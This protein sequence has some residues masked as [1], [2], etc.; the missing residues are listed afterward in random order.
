MA[1]KKNT[2]RTAIPESPFILGG[3]SFISQLG[4][5]PPLS[6]SGQRLLVE[7]CLEHGI[8]W[9]DTT[10][11]PERVALGKALKQLGARDQ[12]V[13]IAW[14]FFTDFKDRDPVGGAEYYRPHH[15]EMM[16]EQLKTDYI[17]CLVVH[18]LGNP[19]EDARQMELAVEW[20]R[21]GYITSLGTWLPGS[22]VEEIFRDSPYTFMIKPY[23]IRTRE[24]TPVFDACRRQGWLNLACSP[25]IRG[26]ELDKM[27]EWARQ[28]EP[29]ASGDAL[30]TRL[31]DHLLRFSLFGPHVDRLI[32]AIRQ[33][34]W[35]TTNCASWR[36]G[37][38]S[39]EEKS[40]LLERA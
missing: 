19:D 31:A 12:A 20:L 23:N 1:D 24:S 3:H 30:K 10:Y 21:K 40:W 39:P 18:A 7:T 16:L 22:D 35:V 38:L 36:K 17:D 27:T 8:T 14:N 37:P 32:V 26:W 15:I 9:F 6:K 29:D 4:N 5:D 28:K 2:H 34:S 25:F 11:Q 13:I 33:P